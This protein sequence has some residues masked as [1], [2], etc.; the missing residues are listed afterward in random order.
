M[1]STGRSPNRASALILF[2]SQ[3]AFR[4]PTLPEVRLRTLATK[5][6][7]RDRRRQVVNEADRIEAKHLLTLQEGVAE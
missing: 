3:A 5:T 7:C 6:T 4:D 1:S 2:P